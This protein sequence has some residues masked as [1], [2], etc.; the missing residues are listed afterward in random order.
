MDLE[1][2]VV[3]VAKS[4]NKERLR[5]NLEIFDER[6]RVKE[7]CGYPAKLG[8]MFISKTDAIKSAEELWDGEL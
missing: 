2:G 6:R 4:F 7:D 3:I 8:K 1:Q 5:K